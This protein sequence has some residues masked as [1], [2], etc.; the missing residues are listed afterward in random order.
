M[1]NLKLADA[2]AP[3]FETRSTRKCSYC[4]N[5]WRVF[6]DPGYTCPKCGK[7]IREVVKLNITK[8]MD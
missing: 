1:T 2:Y 4:G 8:E 3:K 5:S 6:D 7:D